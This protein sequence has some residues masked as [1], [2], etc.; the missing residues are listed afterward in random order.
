MHKYTNQLINEQSPYLLQHAHNPVNWYAW[1]NEALQ[2]ALSQDKPILIS[3][4][5]AACHWCHVME[6]ESFENEE[7]AAYMNEHF[8][9]IKVDREER[10]DLDHIYMDAVTAIS[11]S[12]GWPLNC[13]LTPDGKPFYG[14]TYFP[15]K[16]MY[17]K[18]DW[19][20]LLRSLIRTFKEK[21]SDIEQ[22]ANQLTYHLLT[23][24]KTV[25]QS[26]IFDLNV[27]QPFEQ[28]L[29][30]TMFVRMSKQF[31]KEDG[32][33][34]GAPKFPGT[35]N[36]Q[37]LLFYHHFT[38]DRPALQH[39]LFSI[40][41]MC[42]GGIYDHL[43][44]GFAR[45]TV[46]KAWLVPHF[47]KMLYDNALLISLLA[48]AYKISRKSE[49][50]ETIEQTIAFILTD[51]TSA[52][53]GFYA[54]YDADSEGEEGKYY[55]W[56]KAEIDRILHDDA[57][58]FNLF[59]GVTAQG[60]WE[61]KNILNR[62]FTYKAF[63]DKTGYSVEQ[64]KNMFQRCKRLLMAHRTDRVKPA[65]DDKILLSWN[66]L[67][68]T[69]FAHAYTALGHEQ[70]K[71]TAITNLQFLLNKFAHPTR[72]NALLHSYKNGAARHPAFL[73]D[74][75]FLIE[76]LLAVYQITFDENLL[77]RA[78]AFAQFVQQHFADPQSHAFYYTPD[79]QT[80]IVVRAKEFYDSA[81]P[82]G[83]SVMAAN[84]RRLGIML[85]IP[86]YVEQSA[87]MVKAIET[88][89]VK[90]PASFAQWGKTALQFCFPAHEVAILGNNAPAIA[91][92]LQAHY[93]PNAVFMAAT[94]PNSNFELLQNRFQEG[95][96]LVYICQNNAC[97]RP[98]ELLEDALMQLGVKK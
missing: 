45:Y 51:M 65:L 92:K 14:G 24:D 78:L 61:G 53:G 40:D 68:T 15:P 94:H 85:H 18:P 28:D 19:L 34:G 90:Y 96:N 48:D 25:F 50:K 88:S 52:E 16:P 6:R 79:F 74:Y 93:L 55:V 36:L 71:Q 13:F 72:P 84:L 63:A 1:G 98:T 97:H 86:E 21:R 89:M 49:Y 20:T 60:N 47:E 2:L 32:G 46:D 54:S 23:Q 73:D 22:Q 75:A 8:I 44:G 77:Q 30:E 3:I 41:K 95:K 9:N 56:S 38:N 26:A 82:S 87:Y 83:N 4:G 62:K 43:A 31:D 42:A 17:G 27:Q 69:A 66:A 29:P 91:Q 35:M 59:Y 39:A 11:G 80:D 57:P 58:V 5:Y 64:L 12:G 81:T 33:F 70:Y 10:P 7:V 37:W 67:M 76:A